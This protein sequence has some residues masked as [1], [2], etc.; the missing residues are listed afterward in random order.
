MIGKIKSKSTRIAEFLY[1][2]NFGT[3]SLQERGEE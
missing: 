2:I 1:V 3:I